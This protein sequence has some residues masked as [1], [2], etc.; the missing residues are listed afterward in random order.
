MRILFVISRDLVLSNVLLW[1]KEVQIRI[2]KSL[3]TRNSGLRSYQICEWRDI[4][5]VHYL[6]A[7]KT[8]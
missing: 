7:I 6:K 5:Y 3:N 1:G 8:E 4:S 2:W